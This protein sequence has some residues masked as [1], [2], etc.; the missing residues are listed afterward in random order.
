MDV[1]GQYKQMLGAEWDKDLRG[2]HDLRGATETTLY[3][4]CWRSFL[5]PKRSMID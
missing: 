4:A 5:T 2:Q 1:I 3:S